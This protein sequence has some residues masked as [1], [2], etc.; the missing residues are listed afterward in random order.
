MPKIIEY[1]YVEYGHP[2]QYVPRNTIYLDVGSSFTAGVID[3][4][5]LK[6]HKT[7]TSATRMIWKLLSDSD[8]SP[9]ENASD[10]RAMITQMTEDPSVSVRIVTHKN[11]DLDSFVSA[12][13]LSSY[14]RDHKLPSI[15]GELIDLV[16]RAD[17]G[18][19]DDKRFESPNIYMALEVLE[20][21]LKEL[22]GTRKYEVLRE[23]F[24][25]LL[26]RFLASGKPETE[27]LEVSELGEKCK[28]LLEGVKNPNKNTVNV[29]LPVFYRSDEGFTVKERDALWID[30]QADQVF[31]IIKAKYRRPEGPV[32]IVRY[33]EDLNNGKH[34]LVISVDGDDKYALFGYGWRIE[35]L[36]QEYRKGYEGKR[37]EGY[38]E[39]KGPPRPG[40]D[41]P[42]PWWDGRNSHYTI[43]DSPNS[44][45]VL[46]ELGKDG[47]L[48]LL[49]Q[50]DKGW[51]LDLVEAVLDHLMRILDQPPNKGNLREEE[52]TKQVSE[53]KGE[54]QTAIA[55]A[56]AI[57]NYV[58]G[59]RAL[60]ERLN[61][62]L[63]GLGM[64]Y[65][66]LQGFLA[67]HFPDLWEKLQDLKD[68]T[69]MW[70]EIGRFLFEDSG[71]EV[72]DAAMSIHG[73]RFE[74]KSDRIPPLFV[75]LGKLASPVRMEWLSRVA[76]L[77]DHLSKLSHSSQDQPPFYR[78][79]EYAELLGQLK[80]WKNDEGCAVWEGLNQ[81]HELPQKELIGFLGINNPILPVV[82]SSQE[83][84]ELPLYIRQILKTDKDLSGD[85]FT[86]QSHLKFMEVAL[87]WYELA[88]FLSGSK[89]RYCKKCRECISE[90]PEI[91]EVAMPPA[92]KL[93]SACKDLTGMPEHLCPL[94]QDIS[95]IAQSTQKFFENQNQEP[96]L[97]LSHTQETLDL[98]QNLHNR[99][100]GLR[101]DQKKDLMWPEKLIEDALWDV[102]AFFLQLAETLETFERVL[103]SEEIEVIE[104]WGLDLLK[105]LTVEQIYDQ[106]AD[107]LPEALE[108]L[109]GQYES[110]ELLDKSGS[111]LDAVREVRSLFVAGKTTTDQGEPDQNR[112]AEL[113]RRLY[114]SEHEAL[115]DLPATLKKNM[116]GRV[117]DCL[118]D[119]MCLGSSADLLDA[120]QGRK[121]RVL[122]VIDPLFCLPV[123]PGT[124]LRAIFSA[125][126]PI[127]A[128]FLAAVFTYEQGGLIW[129]TSL[130]AL[131]LGC[132][133]FQLLGSGRWLSCHYEKIDEW[134]EP[135]AR[136]KEVNRE[137]GV[138]KSREKP[139]G[140]FVS[141]QL[142][143]RFTIPMILALSPFVMSDE[144]KEF[145]YLQINS[146]GRFYSIIIIFGAAS[147]LALAK[148]QPGRIQGRYKNLLRLFA[149]LWAQSFAFAYFLPISLQN[150]PLIKTAENMDIQR[151]SG[152]PRLVK[153]GEIGGMSVYAFPV[154]TIIFSFM[155][156]FAAI[157]L[158]GL[159]KK[160]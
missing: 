106:K 83:R 20:T 77:S 149:A 87:A 99:F 97:V 21:D 148:L 67:C 96:S 154:A 25:D 5:H 138:V 24:F 146:S 50:D 143:L 51:G 9:W 13:I 32:W 74:S 90:L 153:M 16:D 47:L 132:I 23:R 68:Y 141:G 26:D 92:L 150:S 34:R 18:L 28:S 60:S 159:V 145:I 104:K 11:P 37:Y 57:R 130:F 75:A 140:K 91:Q 152:I 134:E 49:N 15:P 142:L 72:L 147:L 84:L 27:F 82:R 48:K 52:Y 88:L 29:K 55:L 69:E 117:I 111:D 81:L 102:H 62:G 85:T 98:I 79:A 45:T 116:L 119:N 80:Q 8:S 155:C 127:A 2:V 36:E 44:G 54:I 64:C 10:T 1:D 7:C 135:L 136:N 100:K 131:W 114:E 41:C 56:L 39:R 35:R 112:L 43:V 121:A 78:I 120:F 124:S 89:E 93:I 113:L 133:L 115:M 118:Q 46:G 123:C 4:H 151:I 110:D 101:K 70:P 65:F 137:A 59:D 40:F 86:D 6:S 12:Y 71:F 38:P 95:G 14:L 128:G 63:A 42:D 76:Q 144:L 53:W 61:E 109:L 122:P 103:A 158:E 139:I 156:L 160:K 105:S 107:L 58:A 126:I 17:R 129:F 73:L 66:D 157:F 94:F 30:I 108:R 125:W 3:H 19:F 22:D 33:P 31:N